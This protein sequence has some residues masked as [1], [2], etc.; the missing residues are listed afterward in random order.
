MGWGM[1]G[2]EVA[3]IFSTCLY[4]RTENCWKLANELKYMVLKLPVLPQ[5]HIFGRTKPL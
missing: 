1:V 3:G 2:G 4:H 5:R